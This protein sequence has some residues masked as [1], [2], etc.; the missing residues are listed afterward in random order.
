M[1]ASIPKY[2][3]PLFLGFLA[4][5]PAE[6]IWAF[7]GGGGGSQTP[8]PKPSGNNVRYTQVTAGEGVLDGV[9]TDL[10]SYRAPDGEII[11]TVRATIGSAADGVASKIFHQKIDNSAAQIIKQENILDGSGQVIGE[12]SVLILV[13]KDGK[14]STSIVITKGADFLELTSASAADV[15]AFEGEYNKAMAAKQ[16]KPK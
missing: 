7:Q 4:L 12:R 2:A 5:A 10:H 6:P 8:S 9:T 14:K 11:V 1:R 15:L 3:L 13:D 16:T